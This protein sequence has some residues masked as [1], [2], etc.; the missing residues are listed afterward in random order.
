MR[1][2]AMRREHKWSARRISPELA[3]EG[4]TV[5]VR[6]VSR[7]LAHLGLNRRR[8]LTRPAKTTANPLGSTPAG[9]ATWFTST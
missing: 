6:T 4:I 8:F 7:H 9:P 5:S 2:E 1:I 3:S